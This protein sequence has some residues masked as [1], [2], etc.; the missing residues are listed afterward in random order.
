[1]AIPTVRQRCEEAQ[2][3]KQATL[4]V[5]CKVPMGYQLGGHGSIP[6]Y[7]DQVTYRCADHVQAEGAWGKCDI[8]DYRA[9]VLQTGGR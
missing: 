7:M 1:M 8:K 2:C 3:K 4:A 9:A 5:A 6:V